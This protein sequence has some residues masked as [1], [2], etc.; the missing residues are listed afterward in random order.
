MSITRRQ[1]A[2][3]ASAAACLPAWAQGQEYPDKTITVTVGFAAGG[4]VDF[5]V[6]SL[7]QGMGQRLGQ[8]MVVDNR[9][10]ASASIACSYV[11]KSRPD[12]Y[13]LLGTD[14]GSLA[15]NGALYSKLPYDPVK[16]FA[17]I[18]LVMRH[19][20]LIVAHPDFP[21]SDLKGLLDHARRSPEGISYA[22]PGLG[23]YHHLG[24]ELLKRRTGLKATPVPYKGAAPA[25]Q[26]VMA[27]HVEVAPI[28]TIPALPQIAAGKLKALAV[29]DSRRMT[30][31]PDVPTAAEL[32]IEGVEVL[33][34][35][36][37][38]APR[39]TPADIVERLSQE[40]RTV[41]AT[42]EVSKH[43]AER[44]L[45]TLTTTPVEFAA[46]LQQEIARWHPLIR[47]LGIRLDL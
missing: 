33:P 5:I 17:P 42:P 13:N 46:I 9:P 8:T 26:D 25:M 29:L 18:S 36:G 31:L 27:G 23:T 47:E 45:Q 32:G 19:P 10:G 12:G 6:R 14:G 24:M 1:F 20:I 2:L 43:F 35:V 22:S 44:G 3:A 38:L 28:D 41:A 30:Q 15:L 34:W 11:A 16:D 21:V 7:A 39:G 40:V 4:G 37:M